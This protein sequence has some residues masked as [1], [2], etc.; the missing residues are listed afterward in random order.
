MSEKPWEVPLSIE[1]QTDL[2]GQMGKWLKN[3]GMTS[4]SFVPSE[5]ENLFRM[6]ATIVLLRAQLAANT[7]TIAAQ[8]ADLLDAAMLIRRLAHR[9]P[10]LAVAHQATDWLKRKGL[11][12]SILRETEDSNG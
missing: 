10:G 9:C 3:G 11:Q 8:A 7:A 6:V 2:F 4:K 1:E 5:M 12:G